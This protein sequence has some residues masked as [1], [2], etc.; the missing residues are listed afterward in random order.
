MSYALRYRWWAVLLGVS[1]A[2]CLVHG[3]SVS[4]A[5]LIFA[6]WAWREGTAEDNVSTTHESRFA[7]LTIVSWFA[8]AEMSDKTSVAT[9]TLAS[10]H[11]WAGGISGFPRSSCTSW[12]ACCSFCPDCGSCSTARRGGG[13]WPLPLLQRWRRRRQSL[14]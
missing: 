5:F 14:R 8:L 7:L 2:A 13:R 10:D 12:P 1:L 4:I 11:N 9:L 6:V 3:I